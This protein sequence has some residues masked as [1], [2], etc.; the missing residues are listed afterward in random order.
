M[1]NQPNEKAS[2]KWEKFYT[3]ILLVNALYV[4]L[5]YLIMKSF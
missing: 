3:I 1:A 4:L 2:Y 5:F